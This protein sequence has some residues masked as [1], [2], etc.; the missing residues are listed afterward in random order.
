MS[1]YGNNRKGRCADSFRLYGIFVTSYS[2][3]KLRRKIL[4][5]PN[6]ETSNIGWKEQHLSAMIKMLTH[7]ICLLPFT[8]VLLNSNMTCLCKQS[9][10]KS[11]DLDL[12]C[13]P[14]SMW[15]Y[16]NSPD[17]LCDWL[18]LRSGC[19]YFERFDA[20]LILIF[21][22]FDLLKWVFE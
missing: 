11:T 5:N 20:L 6:R 9:R 17:Q 21:K 8:L 16:I 3:S 4:L 7:R 19:T 13:L 15:I 12:H 2:C 1:F 18:K 10:P 22:I 14:L